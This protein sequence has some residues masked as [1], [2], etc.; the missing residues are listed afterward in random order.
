MDN[1]S[2]EMI[3]QIL[4]FIPQTVQI[5]VLTLVSKSM[6]STVVG[7]VTEFDYEIEKMLTNDALRKFQFIVKLNLSSNSK[8]MFQKNSK[9][10]QLIL[11]NTSQTE[12]NGTSRNQWLNFQWV[13]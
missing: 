5:T 2:Q 3:E 10:R 8:W 9:V 7:I 6:Q 12:H 11:L 1:L 13:E 4:L